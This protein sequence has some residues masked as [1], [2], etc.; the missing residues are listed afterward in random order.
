[1]IGGHTQ[2]D[3]N[4]PYI[5][6]AFVEANASMDSLQPKA[7]SSWQLSPGEAQ[8]ESA[9]EPLQNHSFTAVQANARPGKPARSNSSYRNLVDKDARM[10]QKPGKPCRLYYLASMAAD[11]SDVLRHPFVTSSRT[12]KPVLHGAYML[13]QKGIPA[14]CCPLLRNSPLSYGSQACQ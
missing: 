1:M 6:A 10:A 2:V 4:D 5:D 8:P 9:T 3:H 11:T 7:V 12:C 13:R 14:I